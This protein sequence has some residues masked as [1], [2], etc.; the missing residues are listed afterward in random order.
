MD[1]PFLA[2]FA[3]TGTVAI[4]VWLLQKC[5]SRDP[6]EMGK[7]SGYSLGEKGYGGRLD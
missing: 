6:R 1:H 7:G 5:V 4:F 2:L 3:L